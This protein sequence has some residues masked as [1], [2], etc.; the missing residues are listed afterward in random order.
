M[1]VLLVPLILAALTSGA[2]WIT[3]RE[4]VIW[5]P[6]EFFLPFLPLGAW[7]ILN[8]FLQNP[9]K[10]LSNFFIEIFGLLLVPII[11]ILIRRFACPGSTTPKI[12][13][14]VCLGFIVI[15]S[16]VYFLTPSLPE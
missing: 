13:I 11:Y 6:A 10:S 2:M 12:G 14:F 1:E 9:T 15:T 3:F 16:A 8:Y 4:L 7:A 5:H